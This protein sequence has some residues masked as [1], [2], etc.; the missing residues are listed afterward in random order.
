MI[1]VLRPIK[2]EEKRNEKQNFTIYYDLVEK[3]KKKKTQNV[4]THEIRTET[5][6]KNDRSWQFSRRMYDTCTDRPRLSK[7]TSTEKLANDCLRVG[8]RIFFP[9][10]GTMFHV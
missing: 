6:P 10:T 9:T 3:K 4:H 2:K 5:T 1:F 8:A 7:R